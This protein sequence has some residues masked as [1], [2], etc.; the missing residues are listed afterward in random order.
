MPGIRDNDPLS[1]IARYGAVSA[2]AVRVLGKAGRITP[3]LGTAST[4]DRSSY[5][6]A[7]WRRAEH[8]VM[9]RP[10]RFSENFSV[11]CAVVPWAW[12]GSAAFVL[13]TTWSGQLASSAGCCGAG[14]GA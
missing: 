4:N 13:S 1:L 12:A 11:A 14:S 3:G 2:V 8:P 10:G 7:V 6:H 9:R 5:G